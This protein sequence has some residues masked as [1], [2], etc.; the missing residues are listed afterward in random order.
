MGQTATK[1]EHSG[2]EISITPTGGIVMKSEQ[3]ELRADQNVIE[4][5]TPVSYINIDSAGCMSMTNEKC[6]LTID[7]KSIEMDAD[8]CKISM[9]GG[10]ISMTTPKSKMSITNNVLQVKIKKNGSFEIGEDMCN[11]NGKFANKIAKGKFKFY[12]NGHPMVPCE[13]LMKIDNP[14]T[15]QFLKEFCGRE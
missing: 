5:K 4:M 1:I 2:N 14:E 8:G 11:V 3:A 10:N 7:Q 13:A 9:V 15:A 6:D 12:T